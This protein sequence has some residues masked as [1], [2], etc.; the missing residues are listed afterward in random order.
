M[1]S[2]ISSLAL[3]ECWQVIVGTQ[4][5]LLTRAGVQDIEK[6]LAEEE[7]GGVEDSKR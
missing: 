7:E 4:Y 5:L 6:S 3:R 1:R 2:P